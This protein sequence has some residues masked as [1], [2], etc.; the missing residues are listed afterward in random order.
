MKKEAITRRIASIER[1]LLELQQQSQDLDDQIV[2]LQS[3][4]AAGTDASR[5]MRLTTDVDILPMVHEEGEGES[6]YESDPR[7]GHDAP[8]LP[9]AQS[10]SARETPVA[11]PP[12]G[13]E[14]ITAFSAPNRPLPRL[15]LLASGSS[16]RFRLGDLFSPKSRAASVVDLDD[17]TASSFNQAFVASPSAQSAPYYLRYGRPVPR[18]LRGP[19]KSSPLVL[20]TGAPPP[21]AAAPAADPTAG[22]ANHL[23]FGEAYSTAAADVTLARK[24]SGRSASWKQG[25]PSEGSGPGASDRARPEDFSPRPSS[26]SSFKVLNNLRRLFGSPSSKSVKVAPA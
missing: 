15:V 7:L 2:R 4:S 23:I 16:G 21:L 3:K 11:P 18:L 24:Y 8:E 10:P 25:R 19:R 6:Q 13:D 22:G 26:G 5:G 9:Y 14:G 12:P 20:G 17:S 1:F